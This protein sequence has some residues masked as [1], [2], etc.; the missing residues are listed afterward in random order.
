MTI[1][2]FKTTNNYQTKKH[3]TASIML[4]IFCFGM[5]IILLTNPAK[6]ASKFLEGFMLFGKSVL[7]GLFPFMLI[8]KMLTSLGFV[9]KLA[10]IC[11]NFTQKVFASPGIGA[12]SLMMSNLSGY[13][14][15]AKI[16]GDLHSNKIISDSDAQNMINYSMTSGPAFVIGSVGAIM[17]SS[18]KVGVVIFASHLISNFITGIILAKRIKSELKTSINHSEPAP[19]KKVSIDKIL[20]DSMYSAI[21]AILI[22]GGFVSCFYCFSEILIDLKVFDIISYP[23]GRFLEFLGAPKTMATSVCSGLLEVTRGCKELSLFF[24][25]FPVLSVSLACFLISFSGLSI[26]FQSKAFLSATKI[27]TRHLILSKG[28]HAIIS[29]FICL[30]ISSL[31][32]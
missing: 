28:V 24:A 26:I 18:V 14:I 32:F 22:V 7:P 31:I 16:I 12:Y 1:S 27:K 6:Y 11:G 4:S 25:S 2:F 13:P 5:I 17:F 9:K 20:S 21:E 30:G 10:S 19:P 8:T 23:L 15:G 29:F 3:D